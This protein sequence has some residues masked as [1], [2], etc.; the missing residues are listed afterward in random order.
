MTLVNSE[1]SKFKLKHSGQKSAGK[2]N[3]GFIHQLARALSKAA[4]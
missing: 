2:K 3:T 1:D 4:K